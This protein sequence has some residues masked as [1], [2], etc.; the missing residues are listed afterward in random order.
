M[1]FFFYLVQVLLLLLLEGHGDVLVGSDAPLVLSDLARAQVLVEIVS[2]SLLVIDQIQN[3]RARIRLSESTNILSLFLVVLESICHVVGQQQVGVVELVCFFYLLELLEV[4]L[5]LSLQT[6]FFCD[7][8]E[9][10]VVENGLHIEPKVETAGLRFE[11]D[12]EV[13]PDFLV[14]AVQVEDQEVLGGAIAQLYRLPLFD[15]VDQ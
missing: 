13:A 4:D 1:L 2:Q 10:L 7:L 6:F 5:V 15:V 11:L 9:F 8:S 12:F 3:G 14:Q